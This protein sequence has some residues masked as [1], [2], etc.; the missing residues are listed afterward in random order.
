MITNYKPEYS[1]MLT[2]H[3]SKG[4][5]LE[6][7]GEVINTNKNELLNWLNTYPDF[8]EAKEVGDKKAIEW[9]EKQEISLPLFFYIKNRFPD[10]WQNILAKKVTNKETNKVT[11]HE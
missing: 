5:S 10:G 4:L 11:K 7:F 6:S 9:A 2:E 1:D 3:M 8:K